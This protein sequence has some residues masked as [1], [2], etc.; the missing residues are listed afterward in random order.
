MWS[1]EYFPCLDSFWYVST[2]KIWYKYFGWCCFWEFKITVNV[3]YQI[4]NKWNKWVAELWTPFNFPW[5]KLSKVIKVKNLTL[6][7]CHA[8]LSPQCQTLSYWRHTSIIQQHVRSF[9]QCGF[10]HCSLQ[11]FSILYSI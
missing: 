6:T 1:Y 11:R 8:Q 5:Q 9:K 4:N 3:G 7:P 10:P 2:C